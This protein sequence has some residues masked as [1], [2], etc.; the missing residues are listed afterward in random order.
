MVSCIF[1][2]AHASSVSR[3]PMFLVVLWNC[4]RC[5]AFVPR[6]L[7]RV[8]FLHISVVLIRWLPIPPTIQTDFTPPFFFLPSLL[9]IPLDFFPVRCGIV[10]FAHSFS[11]LGKN[12]LSVQVEQDST[13]CPHP[14]TLH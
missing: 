5:Y 9:P 7:F 6:L 13:P 14:P 4:G 8:P 11:S 2:H 10:L 12:R 3:C 1:D